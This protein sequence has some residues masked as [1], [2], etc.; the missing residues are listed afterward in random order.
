MTTRHTS[1]N[2]SGHTH[3]DKSIEDILQSIRNVINN[4]EKKQEDAICAAHVLEELVEEEL[5]LTEMIDDMLDK[6]EILS[7]DFVCGELLSDASRSKTESI[8]EDFIETATTLGAHPIEV[9]AVSNVSNTPIEAFMIELLRPQLREW[10]DTNLPNMVKQ[11]VA[12]EIKSLVANI[13]KNSN[14]SS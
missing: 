3:S 4:R 6:K 10:L 11:I 7:S 14:T 12:D 13:R 1:G 9:E 5:H 8:L 2:T